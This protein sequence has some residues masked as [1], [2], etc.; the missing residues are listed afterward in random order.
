M[1]GKELQIIR[2]ALLNEHQAIEFYTLAAGKDNPADVREAFQQLAAEEQQHVE[3]L[4]DLYASIESEGAQSFDPA[5]LAEPAPL[6][7][8][9]ETIGRERGSLAVSVFGIGVKLEKAAIDYY[10]KAAAASELPA[11]KALYEKLIRWEYQHLEQFQK[12]YDLLRDEW[13]EQQGFSPA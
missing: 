2:Q 12:Q 5:T 7:Y 3:W 13:W 10:T 9:A 4:R 1:K 11:A 8:D 6:S